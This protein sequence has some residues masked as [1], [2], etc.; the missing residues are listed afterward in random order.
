MLVIIHL[1]FPNIHSDVCR[2]MISIFTFWL[3]IST[4]LLLLLLVIHQS[5][6]II[7]LYVVIYICILLITSVASHIQS[8]SN[9]NVIVLSFNVLGITLGYQRSG[10]KEATI[11]LPKLKP[12]KIAGFIRES[13]FGFLLTFLFPFHSSPFKATHLWSQHKRGIRENYFNYR[14][15]KLFAHYITLY[16]GAKY[17]KLKE[18]R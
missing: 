5:N 8:V 17:H 4:L 14:Q 16:L 3:I 15:D 18:W 6:L 1:C 13:F 12:N 2:P 7:E 11:R 9:E 10:K